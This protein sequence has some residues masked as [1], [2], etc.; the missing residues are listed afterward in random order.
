M[1][2]HFA[3]PEAEEFR[4]HEMEE[5]P[6]PHGLRVRRLFAL[7]VAGLQRM[8]RF[9]LVLWIGGRHGATEPR[10]SRRAALTDPSPRRPHGEEAHRAVWLNQR[11][12]LRH[13]P[14]RRRTWKWTSFRRHFHVRLLRVRGLLRI[15]RCRVPP[16]DGWR[17]RGSVLRSPWGWQETPFPLDR[18]RPGRSCL[19][20]RS[21]ARGR[22]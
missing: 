9:R 2:R 20:R 19:L 7:P 15:T 5:I 21:A 14:S 18:A 17:R 1:T 3:A 16:R 13:R 12:P 22:P 6:L 4:R 10:L 11:G 8:R